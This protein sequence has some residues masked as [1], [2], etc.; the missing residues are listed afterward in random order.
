MSKLLK[1]LLA[2]VLAF[3][4]SLSGISTIV[5]AEEPEESPEYTAETT[6]EEEGE[7]VLSEEGDEENIIVISE[8]EQEEPEEPLPEIDL[9]TRHLAPEDY[10]EEIGKK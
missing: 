10:L 6:V 4:T 5:H 9:E 1:Q 8:E 3:Q 7:T 2:V